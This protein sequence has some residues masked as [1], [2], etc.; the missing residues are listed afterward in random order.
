[1]KKSVGGGSTTIYLGKDYEVEGTITRAL[2]DVSF[3][4]KEG[5]FVA[6]MGPSGSGK[7]TA[8]NMI[9]CL[10]VPPKGTAGLGRSNVSGSNRSPLPPARIKV[11]VLAVS[12]CTSFKRPSYNKN[13]RRGCTIPAKTESHGAMSFQRVVHKD[14]V[15]TDTARLAA[16]SFLSEVHRSSRWFLPTCRI[17]PGP[18]CCN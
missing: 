8:V 14:S 18:T 9:G 10:D 13:V 1:M 12:V 4:I 17:T 3:E 15:T 2:D 6:I 16:R 7:S 5:E 11:C